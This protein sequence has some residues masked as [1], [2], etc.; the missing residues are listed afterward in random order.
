MYGTWKEGWGECVRRCNKLG[1]GGECV[2]ECNKLGRRGE[3][4]RICNS[5]INIVNRARRNRSLPTRKCNQTA[6]TPAAILPFRFISS[7]P[8]SLVPTSHF[9]CPSAPC[10]LVYSLQL[11]ALLVRSG[12]EMYSTS[13]VKQK[14]RGYENATETYNKGLN[15]NE[16]AALSGA[17]FATGSNERSM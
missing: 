3:C 1:R 11:C 13:P 9:P 15:R 5:R 2:R 12:I 14:N 7:S 8:T 16:T 6:T 17:S 10:V 4:V